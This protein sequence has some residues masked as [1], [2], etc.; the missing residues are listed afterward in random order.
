[1]FNNLAS[2]CRGP[3]GRVLFAEDLVRCEDWE[4]ELRVY[5]LCRVIA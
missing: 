1:M 5:H 3:L 4:F 2:E